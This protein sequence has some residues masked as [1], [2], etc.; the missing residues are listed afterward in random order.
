MSFTRRTIIT[1]F[2]GAA[3]VLF[4]VIVFV[5]LVF[6]VAVVVIVFVVVVF[7]FLVIVF[8]KEDNHD[9]VAGA[10]AGPLQWVFLGELLPPD[11]K[12]IVSILV[13]ILGFSFV[14]D[15]RDNCR[16]WPG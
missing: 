13:K 14:R 3:L 16:F 2:A 11:Y 7:V 9:N 15:L 4:S 6:I 8:D 1:S 5:V 10:G 12:V